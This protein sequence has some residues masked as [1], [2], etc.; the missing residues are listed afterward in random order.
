ML[1]SCRNS[2]L[3]YLQGLTCTGAY[4]LLVYRS[5]TTPMTRP[6]HRPVATQK[7]MYQFLTTRV[8]SLGK[9]P[10]NSLGRP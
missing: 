3:S 7:N 2:L 6:P 8:G 10:T 5:V 9:M 4:A 1:A